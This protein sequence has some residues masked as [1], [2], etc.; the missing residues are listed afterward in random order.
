MSTSKNKN[1]HFGLKDY[2]LMYKKRGLRL[3]IYFFFQTHL[4]DLMYGTDTHIWLPKKK[5]NSKP[6]NFQHGVL[7]MC[8]WTNIIKDAT[9]KVIDL[10]SLNPNDIAFIDIGCGKGK[11]LCVWK[12]M[13]LNSK[14]II[15]IDYSL[16]LLKICKKN[17]K[18][19]SASE[20]ELICAD[21]S[22]ISLNFD[23]NTQLFYLYNPFNEKILNKFIDSI[24][25]NNAI[26]IYN[27]P[28]H[29]NIFLKKGYK[30][31]FNK[32]SWHPNGNFSIFSK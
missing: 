8:S 23:C 21:A 24:K 6:K 3:P 12:K 7:Y 10:F 2:F 15:G 29:K 13:F 5:Y 11:V 31:I 26:I 1:I 22:E 18:K 30:E 19:I 14:K 27:N 32:V 20:V 16:Q 17:L 9:N 25:K 28:V 4:F